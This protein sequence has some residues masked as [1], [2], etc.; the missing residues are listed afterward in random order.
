MYN[1]AIKNNPKIRIFYLNKGNMS[2]II[3]DKLYKINKNFPKYLKCQIN[4]WKL[5][6]MMQ[7]HI[8]SKG[9]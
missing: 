6:K 1:K 3:K 8:F 5:S 7:L 4:S 2:L 9:Y